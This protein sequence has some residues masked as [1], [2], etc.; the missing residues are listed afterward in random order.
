MKWD[1]KCLLFFR[2]PCDKSLPIYYFYQIKVTTANMS[3][4]VGINEEELEPSLELPLPITESNMEPD[5]ETNQEVIP[6]LVR[7]STHTDAE[8]KNTPGIDEITSNDKVNPNDEKL[9]EII[10]N[11]KNN[12]YEEK[13]SEIISE[14]NKNDLDGAAASFTEENLSLPVNPLPGV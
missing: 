3:G 6:S 13:L 11:D 7:A 10:S 5:L 8:I 14:D 1:T 4:N 2:K 12:S 9:S